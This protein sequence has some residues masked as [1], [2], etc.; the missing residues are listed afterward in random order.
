M[1]C[2]VPPCSTQKWL[3]RVAFMEAAGDRWWPIA[4]G[5]YFLQAVKRVNGMR[6][7]TPTWSE[8]LVPAQSLAAAPKTVRQPDDAVAARV[9]E[10]A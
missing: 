9:T 8:R 5:I 4:G 6:L 10:K 2:Y 7:I 1:A 3:D